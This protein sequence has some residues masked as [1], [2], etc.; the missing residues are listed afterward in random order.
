MDQRPEFK[1]SNTE[2]SRRKHKEYYSRDRS[3]QK[4]PEYNTKNIGTC[5]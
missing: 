3:R 1:T 4:L 5:P 2:L